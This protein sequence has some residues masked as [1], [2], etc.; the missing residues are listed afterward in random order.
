MEDIKRNEE[1][2]ERTAKA[3]KELGVSVQRFSKGL[4][5]FNKAFNQY[6]ESIKNSE[7]S[8]EMRENL[9]KKKAEI[10][11][12][13]NTLG[14]KK[15]EVAQYLTDEI[16]AQAVC[17][18]YCPQT[19]CECLIPDEAFKDV[20]GRTLEQSGIRYFESMSVPFMNKQTD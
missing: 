16:L 13:T 11:E 4:A 14:L 6:C 12:Y 8:T 15:S 18:E 19:V 17:F 7:V 10:I 5:N 3:I 9:D 2:K 20:Y 1:L